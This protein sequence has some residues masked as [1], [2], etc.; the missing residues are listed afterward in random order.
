MIAKQEFCHTIYLPER[1]GDA[2]NFMRNI[3]AKQLEE[4]GGDPSRAEVCI[5]TSLQGM[6]LEEVAQDYVC[7]M[8][9]I[10]HLVD[11]LR[12]ASPEAAE[13]FESEATLQ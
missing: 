11:E 6:P 10:L 8:E 12:I 9:T 1:K 5:A 7:F 2:M 4:I 3:P 13:R